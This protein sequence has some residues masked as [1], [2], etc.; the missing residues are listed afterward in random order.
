MKF[1]LQIF[2]A[3]LLGIVTFNGAPVMAF[4]EANPRS[5]Q[6]ADFDWR[7]RLGDSAG[8]TALAFDDSA[9]RHADRS[10]AESVLTTVGEPVHLWLTSNRNLVRADGQDLSFVVV[11]AI[12]EKG[13]LQMNAQQAIQF[14]ISGPGM[15]AAV[16]NGDAQDQ[17]SYQ[18]S[19]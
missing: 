16:G 4:G 8:A 6:S 2:T 5:V 19:H 18:G 1:R 3:I 10:V 14:S 9:W 17:D 11:E 13:R 12:D 7:F 15:I